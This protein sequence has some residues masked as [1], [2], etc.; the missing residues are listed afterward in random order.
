MLQGLVYYVF[1]VQS[2]RISI[3]EALSHA[4]DL[5]ITAMRKNGLLVRENQGKK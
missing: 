3:T 5:N 1:P 4:G 2:E